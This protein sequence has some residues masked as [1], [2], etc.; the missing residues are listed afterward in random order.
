MVFIAFVV[1]MTFRFTISSLDLKQAALI[2]K[3]VTVLIKVHLRHDLAARAAFGIYSLYV[4]GLLFN[5]TH[6]IKKI[7]K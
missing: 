6:N 3:K 7:N 2:E 1:Y 5:T 4:S